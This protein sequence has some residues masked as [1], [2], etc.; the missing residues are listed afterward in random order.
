[1][2]PQTAGVQTGIPDLSGVALS[3]FMRQSSARPYR[4]AVRALEARVEQPGRSIS[5][6]NP[7]RLA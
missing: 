3:Q 2:M 1:M 7:Q 5:G 6:Y 4:A